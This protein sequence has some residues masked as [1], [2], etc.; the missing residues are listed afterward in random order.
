LSAQV[1]QGRRFAALQRI[2]L[3][4]MVHFR[5]HADHFLA[6]STIAIV[7]GFRKSLVFNKIF[8]LCQG[9]LGACI[10]LDSCTG[11]VVRKKYA[12]HLTLQYGNC[13][14]YCNTWPK[15]TNICGMPVATGANGGYRVCA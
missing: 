8:N 7:A 4:D 3:N 1:V 6:K 14:L 2:Y 10:N 11:I 12:N 13:I 5:A 15:Q 9:S